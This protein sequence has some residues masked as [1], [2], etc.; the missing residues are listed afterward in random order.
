MET[1][2]EFVITNF[3][4]FPYLKFTIGTTIFNTCIEFYINLR[5]RSRLQEKF[6]PQTVKD[7]GMTQQKFE[8]SNAYALDKMNFGLIRGVYSVIRSISFLYFFFN[9]ALWK[10]TDNQLSAYGYGYATHPILCQLAFSAVGDIFD[11]VIGIPW[12]LYYD[13]VLEEKW[14][15]NKKTQWVFWTDLIKEWIVGFPLNSLLFGIILLILEK[16]GDYWFI[17]AWGFMCVFIFIMMWIFPTFIQPCFNKV[18]K[19]E[20]GDSKEGQTRA[21]IEKLATRI[22]YPLKN[23]YKIDGSK[24][25]GHS[26]AYMYGFCSNKRIVLYDTLMDQ[27]TVEE[28]TAVLGH[29]LGHWS[30]SHTV[31]MLVKMQ[32]TIFVSLFLIGFF[33][34]D[35]R[36]Y[37]EFGFDTK[38]PFVG[39]SLASNL[40]SPLSSIMKFLNNYQ[41]RVMEYQADR[42]AVNLGYGQT[43]KEGLL[44][45]VEKN[46]K[47]MNPDWLYATYN[48][49]HPEITERVAGIDA[50]VKKQGKKTQ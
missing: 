38:I 9:P 18:E 46:K 33:L 24:R 14:G 8:D 41:T 32:I 7:L 48:Y 47:E 23:L 50:A 21:A 31:I 29:E 10:L 28:I 44:K 2:E 5:Q 3:A 42:F 36:M 16:T 6:M 40:F 4:D 12:A 1:I 17:W 35:E 15:F 39:L 45:M 26:N 25:S 13:F 22:D 37:R 20:D 19:L 49:S 27:M 34:K 30:H 11:S 43:L